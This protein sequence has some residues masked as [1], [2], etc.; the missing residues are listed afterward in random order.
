IKVRG[1]FANAKSARGVR[2]FTPGMFVRVR[3]PL[4]A[5]RAALLVAD[6]AVG[7]DQGQKFLYVLDAENRVQYRRVRTG[8][9]QNDGLRVIGEGLKPDDRVVVSLLQQVRSNIV[10]DPELVPMPIVHTETHSQKPEV[11]TQKSAVNEH[12]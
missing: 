12:K 5:P 2:P 11:R 10:V 6:R 3:L 9:L 8:P 4:G 1:V 7:I